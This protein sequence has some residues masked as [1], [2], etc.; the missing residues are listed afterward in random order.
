MTEERKPETQHCSDKSYRVEVRATGRPIVSDD[1][2]VIGR[3]WEPLPEVRTTP[4]GTAYDQCRDVLTRSHD[5]YGAIAL[6]CSFLSSLHWSAKQ[7]DVRIIEYA[8][9]VDFTMTRTKEMP[10]PNEIDDIFHRAGY[11]ERCSD[12]DKQ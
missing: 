5:Y 1:R 7:V 11:A 2:Q 3:D 10:L 12:E 6:A 9:S 8:R 4:L